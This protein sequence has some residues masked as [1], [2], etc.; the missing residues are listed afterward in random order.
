MRTTLLGV[1]GVV[2][3]SCGGARAQT[4]A[5]SWSSELGGGRPAG[6]LR[7]LAVWDD[8]T[9]PGLFIGA[10]NG[11]GTLSKWDGSRL[12]YHGVFHDE[13]GEGGLS[14]L[15]PFDDGSGG[16]LWGGGSFT[17][18]D[19]VLAANVA[20]WDGQAWHAVGLGA[21]SAVRAFAT[22]DG[23]SG[24]RLYAGGYF[25]RAGTVAS[26]GVAMWNGQQWIGVGGGV[27]GV[28]GVP[29]GYL[30]GTAVFAL[31][32]FEGAGPR[33]LYVGGAFTHAGGVP[34]NG[35]ARWDGSAWSPVG[36]GLSRSTIPGCGLALEVFDDGSGESLFVGGWFNAAGGLSSMGIAR[37]DGQAW[38]AVPAGPPNRYVTALRAC[39][40]GQGRRLYG[41]RGNFGTA[42]VAVLT[43][44]GWSDIPGYTPYMIVNALR[45]FGGGPGARLYA[46]AEQNSGAR[47]LSRTD[48]AAWEPMP[49]DG[50]LNGVTRLETLDDGAGPAL[51]AI[52]NGGSVAGVPALPLVRYDGAT[53]ETVG[54]PALSVSDLEVFDDG[55][56]KKL[57]ANDGVPGSPLH[58]SRLENGHWVGVPGSSSPLVPHPPAR[59]QA[60]DDG[61][62]PR[63]YIAGQ[64][65]GM[66]RAWDGQEW[67]IP[68]GGVPGS[69]VSTNTYDTLVHNGTMYLA[70]DLGVL[71]Y[72]QGLWVRFSNEANGRA[73]ALASSGEGPGTTLYAVFDPEA[74]PPGVVARY[75]TSWQSWVFVGPVG[76]HI[77]GAGEIRWFD[78]GRVPGL[79]AGGRLGLFGGPGDTLVARWDGLSW[80][81]VAQSAVDGG[82]G[83]LA[84]TDFGRP[85]LWAG[86]AFA[87]VNGVSSSNIAAY[88]G[89]EPCYPDCNRDGA[90][91]LADFG[92]FQNRFW[93]PFDPY[94]DCNGD[95]IKNLADFGC[96]QTK[97]ALG[98]P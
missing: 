26:P 49:C 36:T 14:V 19:G 56:G 79:Y 46:C 30:E 54:D 76:M 77:T 97:F 73:V 59:M 92:C 65:E 21:D 2:A 48:G 1:A 52:A 24:P 22:F 41:A 10:R 45:E 91:N 88:E 7:A 38:H 15:F 18:V 8:G 74:S 83:S 12:T 50:A 82:V 70:S 96:F 98:C 89:C 53:W 66:V 93:P 75:D 3:L 84:A 62:G 31:R 11:T 39:D 78:D 68:G 13:G 29:T 80:S 35:I 34:C 6:W 90:L 57:Y 58:V 40:L 42:S 20:R 61:T 51:Y 44:N 81:P 55:A 85:T 60:Y 9:G 33:S 71:A 67:T 47:G 28:C 94:G 87:M 69:F 64:Y 17:E 63:L 23:G 4:C 95:G 43:P 16:S 86:G 27:S 25:T 5:P 32:E 72:G 37:W